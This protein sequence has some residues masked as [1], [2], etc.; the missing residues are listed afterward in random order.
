VVHA[1]RQYS[2]PLMLAVALHALAIAALYTGFSP[3]REISNVIK[4]QIVRSQLLV[5]EQK[6]KP[7][8]A[9]PVREP[10]REP[11]KP[12]E[13]PA[14]AKPEPR[15]DSQV[16][17]RKAEDARKAE[18]A[19][20]TE[21]ARRKAEADR[22]ARLRELAETSFDD[23]LEEEAGDIAVGDAEAVA[24]S[25]RS[26]IYERVVANWSRPPSARH[27]MQ[28]ELLVEL[29]PTGDV[30][31]V[32]VT[33]SSGN[34]AFDRS[35]EAAV[36]KARRFDVPRESEIFERHFRRFALLF[37]PEDLLR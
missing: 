8:P 35:A 29:V 12:V 32:T 28:A 19:R 22:Q 7:A 27:G 37:K 5:L 14:P 17:A 3:K 30:V 33:D 2:L 9:K 20:R 31:A 36:R 13:Q 10:A 4:P 18:E 6:A 15:V 16:E 1:I 26:L 24:Q 21:E 23:L 34:A 11:A 25:Y